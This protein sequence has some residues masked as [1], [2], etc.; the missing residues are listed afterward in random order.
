MI[1]FPFLPRTVF[2]TS[3]FGPRWGKNHNGVDYASIIGT[4]FHAPITGRIFIP[5]FQEGGAGLNIWVIGANGDVWKC[6]HL[7]R[8]LVAN[9]S[10]VSA[11]QHIAETGN[12][13]A[14]TG[15]HAH[16][17]FWPRGFAPVDPLPLLNDAERAMRYP[18]LPGPVHV[19][20]PL[21]PLL[22]EEF[23]AM[24]KYVK[25]ADRKN[26]SEIFVE[27]SLPGLE[28]IDGLGPAGPNRLVGGTVRYDFPDPDFFVLATTQEDRDKIQ[29]LDPKTDGAL[30]AAYDRMPLTIQGK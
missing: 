18:G 28:G 10:W 24:A 7:S 9:H 16:V 12:T 4:D 30:I 8:I 15:P 1:V 27:A 19:T 17:E 6:F 22:P 13:G 14:S 5:M 2:F 20:S 21:P 29:I 26:I 25:V 23:L 3:P 11:G